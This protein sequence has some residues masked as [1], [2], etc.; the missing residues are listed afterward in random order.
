MR[1]L[2]RDVLNPNVLYYFFVVF[3]SKKKQMQ[4]RSA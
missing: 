4:D 1:P 3:F 2:G